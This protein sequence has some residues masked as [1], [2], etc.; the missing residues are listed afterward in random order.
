LIDYDYAMEV[1]SEAENQR[2]A[3]LTAGSASDT[4]AAE[5]PSFDAGEGSVAVRAA[6]NLTP[7]TVRFPHLL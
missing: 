7:R 5:G 6:Q 1:D 4:P 2:E 3:Q